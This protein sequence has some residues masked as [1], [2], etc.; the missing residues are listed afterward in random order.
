MTAA[1][2]RSKA[3]FCQGAGVCVILQKTGS[4]KSL[5]KVLADRN[6][7]PARQVGGREDHPLLTVQGPAAADPD[8][9]RSASLQ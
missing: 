5:E 7:V 3:P 1:L 4:L 6:P 2:A 9:V 8:G